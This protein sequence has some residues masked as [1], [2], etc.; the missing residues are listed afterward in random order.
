MKILLDTQLLLWAAGEEKRL[1]RSIRS[2][3]ENP[4]NE[5]MFSSASLWEIALKCSLGRSD[6]QVEPRLLR[7]GLLDNG[8]VELAVTSLHAVAVA[9]LPPGLKDPFDRILVA[10]SVVER[11]ALLTSDPLVAQYSGL[12]RGA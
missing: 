1:S 9:D 3:I 6:F 10:Q 12:V 7:S 5:P 11:I 2:M 4:D 8:Y